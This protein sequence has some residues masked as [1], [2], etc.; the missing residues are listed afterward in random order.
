MA[1]SITVPITRGAGKELPIPVSV[2]DAQGNATPSG[3]STSPIYTQGASTTPAA[4]V[5]TTAID[6]TKYLGVEIQVT[7][8]GTAAFTRSFANDANYT[9]VSATQSGVA[10]ASPLA[11]GFYN[12]K[13]GGWLTFT[14]TAFVTVRGYN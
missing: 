7:T 1:G 14:G 11:V 9:P 13:G 4:W 12:L 5:T 10:V 8:A 3:T 6:M 2:F